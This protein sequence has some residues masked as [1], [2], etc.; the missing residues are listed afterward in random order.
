MDVSQYANLT[1]ELQQ[2]A[3]KLDCLAP[4]LWASN[5]IVG[6]GAQRLKH[7]HASGRIIS[8]LLP[9]II[10]DAKAENI[11]ERAL[12]ATAASVLRTR[13]AAGDIPLAAPTLRQ[14]QVDILAKLTV[15]RRASKSGGTCAATGSGKVT[16]S[17]QPVHADR[18]PSALP[19]LPLLS[20]RP[21]PPPPHPA[22]PQSIIQVEDMLRA[23]ADDPKIGKLPSLTTAPR[24]QLVLQLASEYHSWERART[25]AGPPHLQ[26]GQ[27]E[28]GR[29]VAAGKMRRF[30]YVVCSASEAN[31]CSTTLRIIPVR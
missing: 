22:P 23:E 1:W 29:K 24:I 2:A 27:D 15:A 28:L 12:E 6:P 19:A 17:A 18:T 11:F 5:T 7:T 25:L 16:A 14:H 31:I 8:W 30:Y 3:E 10:R 4:L 20:E 13:T 26:P 9:D 21:C